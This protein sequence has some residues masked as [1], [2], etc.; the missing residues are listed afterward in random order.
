MLFAAFYVPAFG[1]T[2]QHSTRKKNKKRKTTG[3]GN[4]KKL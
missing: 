3:N 4:K 2:M 1:E